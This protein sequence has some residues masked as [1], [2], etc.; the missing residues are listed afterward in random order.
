MEPLFP[1]SCTE[2]AA[3]DHRSV[4]PAALLGSA[5]HLVFFGVY[6]NNC[7]LKSWD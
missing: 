6:G 3:A 4:A 5:P 2:E 1:R 7:N